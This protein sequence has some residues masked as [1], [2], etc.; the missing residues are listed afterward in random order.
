MQVLRRLTL[1]FLQLLMLWMI[2]LRLLMKLLLKL[3]FLK[4]TLKFLQQVAFLFQ[5][6]LITGLQQY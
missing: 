6:L 3:T 4:T 2:L 1:L 5:L